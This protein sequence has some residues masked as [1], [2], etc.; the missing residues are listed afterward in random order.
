MTELFKLENIKKIYK[1]GEIE[2]V[3][4]KQINLK[5]DEGE[6]IAIIGPSGSG[7]STLMN[8]IGGM[9]KA[10]E[11][12]YILKGKDIS[13]VSTN[14][15]SKFRNKE[16]GFVFQSFNLLPRVRVIDNV[17]LPLAYSGINKRERDK[18]AIEV[19]KKIGLDDKQKNKPNQLS[20]G[21]QQRVAIAR[22]IINNPSILLADEPTGNLDTKSSREILD[23]FTN[24]NKEGK[25]VI[26]ITHDMNIAKYA[27]RIVNI[28]DGEII[29]DNITN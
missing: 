6:M 11:G 20:G 19:L 2:F 1:T 27:N 15:L 21:Q 28:V 29:S 10:T 3:A 26:I 12:K 8:I 25:T 23:I 22:A 5:V 7:K 9:D 17:G 13:K 24:L 16:I 18:K 14:E 4:L